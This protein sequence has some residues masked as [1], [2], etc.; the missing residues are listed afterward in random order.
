MTRLAP[1]KRHNPA[2]S[3]QKDSSLAPE[4]STPRAVCR[5]HVGQSGDVDTTSVFGPPLI[6]ESLSEEWLSTLP[7]SIAMFLHRWARHGYCPPI[8]ALRRLG[9]RT[10]EEIE[11]ERLA[12]LYGCWRW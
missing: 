1:Y 12:R 5:Q 7:T 6:I 11:A 2:R 8:P 9:L 3:V 10:A 4:Q